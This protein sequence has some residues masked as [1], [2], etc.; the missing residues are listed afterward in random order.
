MFSRRKEFRACI[1]P[2]SW[3]TIQFSQV[4]APLQQPSASVHSQLSSKQPRNQQK[5]FRCQPER[6]EFFFYTFQMMC[7]FNRITLALS[8]MDTRG[9]RVPKTHSSP[10]HPEVPSLLLFYALRQGLTHWL[11]FLRQQML[12]WPAQVSLE[13]LTKMS[14]KLPAAP[15]VHCA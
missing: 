14:V 5:Q 13:A 3:S 7:W 2:P 12:A 10:T 8:I 4:I 1:F 15:S 11:V 9:F 6:N